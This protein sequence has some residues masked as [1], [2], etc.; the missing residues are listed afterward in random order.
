[1]EKNFDEAL[2]YFLKSAEM[3]NNE[4]LF[5]LG[6][7]YHYGKTKIKT[8]IEKAIFYYEKSSRLGNTNSMINLG[9]I[10]QNQ[11][12][13][14]SKNESSQQN[15]FDFNNSFFNEK[16]FFFLNLKNTKN[17]NF[18]SNHYFNLQKKNFFFT[19]PSSYQIVQIS[20][21]QNFNKNQTNI[22]NQLQFEEEEEE[23]EENEFIEKLPKEE[24]EKREK[25]KNENTLF[26][27]YLYQKAFL[28]GNSNSLN[29]LALIF[30]NGAPVKIFYFDFLFFLFLI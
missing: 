15:F 4:S 18:F 20:K 19:F 5:Y 9:I 23:E 24:I 7:F 10:F 21:N 25:I 6:C 16:N 26:S 13:L 27:I 1:M 8:D 12:I 29:N 22:L 2:E 3:E 17:Q 28:L 30:H 11:Q 14:I